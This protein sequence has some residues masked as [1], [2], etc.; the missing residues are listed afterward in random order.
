M[1]K[2]SVRFIA[3]STNS[4]LLKWVAQCLAGQS[5]C[6]IPTD[7]GPSWRNGIALCCLINLLC[8]QASLDAARLKPY[9][10]LK[11]CR[12]ALRLANQHLHLPLVSCYT[13]AMFAHRDN[14]VRLLVNSL[15]ESFHV[16]N[17]EVAHLWHDR[18]A[19]SLSSVIHRRRQ[20]P[21]SQLR[22]LASMLL[23]LV[24]ELPWTFSGSA[25]KTSS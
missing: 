17:R 25:H 12:L 23:F 20:R 10:R 21:Q 8:P 4:Q 22:A 11:N 13:V 6:S 5:I 15:F 7:L 9:H 16:V 14:N 2:L 1:C 3:D 18:W 19:L 24:L